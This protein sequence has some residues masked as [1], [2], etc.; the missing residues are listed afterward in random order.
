MVIAGVPVDRLPGSQRQW[1]ARDVAAHRHMSRHPPSDHF[2]FPRSGLLGQ[3]FQNASQNPLADFMVKDPE[4]WIR[5]ANAA[6]L[7]ISG[8]ARK[9]D[10]SPHMKCPRTTLPLMSSGRPNLSTSMPPWQN[11]SRISGLRW[12]TSADMLGPYPAL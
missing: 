12:A 10:P 5:P 6:S 1:S 9:P 11:Y 2:H 3:R 7:P 4:P 8:S